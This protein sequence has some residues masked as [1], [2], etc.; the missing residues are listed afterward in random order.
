MGKMSCNQITKNPL[1][2]YA[3]THGMHRVNPF[4][5]RTARQPGKYGDIA[6]PKFLVGKNLYDLELWG[7][8][9]AACRLNRTVV[10]DA[11]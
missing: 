7:A 10:C 6:R 3:K 5:Y 11:H 2:I 9:E 4:Q 1:N 8:L